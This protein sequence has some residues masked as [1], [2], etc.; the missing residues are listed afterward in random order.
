MEAVKFNPNSGLLEAI[1]YF[2][3][4]I[5]CLETVSTAK[6]PKGPECP[7][8]QSK[9][10]SFLKTRLMW[11]CLD[12]RKQFSVK[13]GTIFEDSAIG[14]DKWLVA[15]WLVANCKNGV[16]SYEVA[17]DLKV[18]QRTA[19]FMLHRIRYAMH[20]G[21]INKMTGTV[22]ADETFIGGKARNMHFGK[23]AEKIRGRGPMGKAIV[24]GLLDRE[25]GKVHTSVVGGRR[26]QHLH[27]EIRQH[28][29]AGSELHTDALK[30]YEGL[31]G[32]T[33]KVVDHAETYVDGNVHT[34]RLENFWSL[35]KRAIKGTYVSVEPFHLFRYLDEQSFR[36]N[37]R[38]L[39]DAQRFVKVL[40]GVAGKRLTYARVRG[41][42]MNQ[43]PQRDKVEAEEKQRKPKRPPGYRK[44][45]KLLKQVVNAPPMRKQN[46]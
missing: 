16:S 24:F 4:P 39:T 28:V 42:T 6:W 17:R 2:S 41:V 23:R 15:M 45:Q 3:D 29:Q 35:L 34:N 22:E 31:A 5:V 37:E 11:T 18:T 7:R 43:E 33:H 19:W 46:S 36:Y 21:T 12:C 32:F 25:T 44:F 27:R 20:H 13:V 14:L 30:S 1:R 26:K 8:C 40:R 10:L 9:R 38:E